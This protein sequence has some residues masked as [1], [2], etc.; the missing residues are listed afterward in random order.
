M[1]SPDL[2]GIQQLR[3]VIDELC[4]RTTDLLHPGVT[5]D[6]LRPDHREPLPADAAGQCDAARWRRCSSP[7]A[8]PSAMLKAAN[9]LVLTQP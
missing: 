7:M 1:A 2:E 8:V 5:T 4:A 9:R 6:G 3:L